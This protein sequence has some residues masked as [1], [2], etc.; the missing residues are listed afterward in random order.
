MTRIRIRKM[1]MT[2]TTKLMTQMMMK[3]MKKLSKK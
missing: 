1:M 3:I 2:R